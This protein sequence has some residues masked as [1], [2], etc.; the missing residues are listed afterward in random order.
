MTV[1]LLRDDGDSGF[2]CC[3]EDG[4]GVEEQGAAC[5]DGEAGGAGGSHGF[6]GGNADD[7][8]V[9][10]HVLIGLGDLYDGERAAEGRFCL[11]GGGYFMVYFKIEGAEEG[12]GAGDG[13]V[14]A[15]HGFDGDA[16]LGGD[17]DGLAEVVGGDAW[18][19]VRP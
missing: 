3:V 11:L 10:A 13:G 17:D 4:F 8:D 19:T 2:V 14:G 9:E 5:F 1:S 7:G 16:G 12:S 18:A 6:D 15:L